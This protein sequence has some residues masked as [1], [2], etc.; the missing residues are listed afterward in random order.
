MLVPRRGSPLPD[1]GRRPDAA[2]MAKLG[3]H[4]R[5]DRRRDRRGEPADR[6]V[7]TRSQPKAGWPVAKSGRCS[8]SRRPNS[9]NVLVEDPA[10]GCARWNLDAP[11]RSVTR[12]RTLRL[13][14]FDPDQPHLLAA[15]PG[16]APRV[17]LSEHP[18]LAEIC[19]EH[20][21]SLYR[22]GEA[23]TADVPYGL[24]R[25]ACGLLR[26]NVVRAI[27][28]D[29]VV[30]GGGRGDPEPPDP[31]D[32]CASRSV[33]R[34]A[35]RARRPLGRRLRDQS[36]P[37]RDLPLPRRS[38][39]RSSRNCKYRPV[40]SSNGPTD[41]AVAS[42][43]SR[44]MCCR[45][46]SRHCRAHVWRRCRKGVN[47][48][49]YFRSEFGIGE[50]ARLLVDG[51]DAAEIPHVTTTY[52]RAPTRHGHAFEDRGGGQPYAT[53]IVCVNV[54]RLEQF[55]NDAGPE[56]FD[57]SPYRRLLVVGGRRAA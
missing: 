14:D 49:G 29:A 9:R 50:A 12:A 54:D 5:R 2:D 38:A 32:R 20:A 46:A 31:Y 23:V 28:R 57:R 47:V 51:L 3:R 10:H 18:D 55:A 15:R 52:T 17:L 44:P 34:L 25:L 40:H 16:E 26:D 4:R 24:D 27:Y 1:D 53:N 7:G 39:R 56:F 22:H 36:L 48:A 6:L 30:S 19:R 42:C 41:M 21:D 33:P 13:A 11:G 37:V 8:M 43:A 35:G 45:R